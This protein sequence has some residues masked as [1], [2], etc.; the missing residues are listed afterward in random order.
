MFLNKKDLREENPWV[1]VDRKTWQIL[2]V[3]NF[4]DINKSKMDT[5]KKINIQ[6]CILWCDKYKIP[7]NK[8]TDKVNIFL[9]SPVEDI[10]EID[11]IEPINISTLINNDLVDN[12]SFSKQYELLNI[13]NVID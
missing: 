7:S 6:K 13:F 5:I 9:S 11:E 8:I 1:R 10:F 3:G 4:E 12:S 2:Q